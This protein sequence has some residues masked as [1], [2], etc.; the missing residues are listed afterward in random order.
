M[1]EKVFLKRF[2]VRVELRPPGPLRFAAL[3]DEV[4]D[5]TDAPAFFRGPSGGLDLGLGILNSENGPGMAHRDLLLKKHGLD[6]VRE[7]EQPEEIG[8]RGPVLADFFGHFLLGY[9]R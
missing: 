7:I 4:L 9:S 5:L 8:H 3:V 1:L 6:G 2:Q